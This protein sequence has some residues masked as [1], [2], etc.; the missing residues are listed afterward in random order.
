[1][2][3]RELLRR[4]GIS[5]ASGVVLAGCLDDESAGSNGDGD[6]SEDDSSRDGQANAT[7]G[8][9]SDDGTA[10]GDGSAG[11]SSTG[12]Q[13][14]KGVSFSPLSFEEVDFNRFFEEEAPAAG[15]VVRGAGDWA[16]LESVSSSFGFVA[17]LAD[18]YKYTP[19]IEVG[20]KDGRTGE[21]TRPLTSDT[22]DS[23]VD[24]MTSLLQEYDVPYVGIG[25]EVNR[26]AT[27]N[28]EGFD[29]YASL[30]N[31]TK[32]EINTVS[33]DTTV[34]AVWQLEW[35][36]GLRGGLWGGENDTSLA[37]WDLLDEVDSDMPAFTTYPYL[38]YDTPAEIPDD[39]YA[40]VV[41]EVGEPIAITEIGWPADLSISGW[42]A[43]EAEQADFI[44]RLETL[45]DGVAVELLIW[46]YVYGQV[47]GNTF[48]T[49]TLKRDDGS[50][51]PAWDAW[52]EAEF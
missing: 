11:D 18:Q 4:A 21:L 30:F 42:E 52:R 17:Q 43:D 33:P 12:G 32:D 41:D 23:Y 35:L 44:P 1:M 46:L 24:Y 39:Y 25:V 40:S 48:E 22:R 5:S 16:E 37:Q 47:E 28:P 8:G 10:G 31:R 14:L 2:R 6:R 38:V 36:L 29:E 50:N 13:G 34:Y 20:V 15:S 27:V 51:R 49:V 7:G 45:L 19:V 26:L 3:R 9:S